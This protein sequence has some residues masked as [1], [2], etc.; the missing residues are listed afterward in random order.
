MKRRRGRPPKKNRSPAD[1]G[2]GVDEAPSSTSKGK[3]TGADSQSLGLRPHCCGACPCTPA[4]SW[5][6]ASRTP[7]SSQTLSP[8]SYH[9]WEKRRRGRPPK[10]LRSAPSWDHFLSRGWQLREPDTATP[11]AHHPAATPVTPVLSCHGRWAA[12][13]HLPTST[14][15]P[16]AQR[17]RL[18]KNPPSLG[19]ASSLSWTATQPVPKSCGLGKQRQTQGQGVSEGSSSDEDGKPPRTRSW[20][21]PRVLKQRECDERVKGPWWWL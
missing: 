2:R 12:P 18:P 1:A 15:S 6:S 4:Y 13:Y 9:L 14:S 17:G 3:T 7:A 21:G 11:A 20:P 10:A 16:E 8:S 19:P 5:A